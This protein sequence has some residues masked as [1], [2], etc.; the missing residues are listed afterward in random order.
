MNVLRLISPS[1]KMKKTSVFS[2][3]S[4]IF[5]VLFFNFSN[6]TLAAMFNQGPTRSSNQS[7]SGESRASSGRVLGCAVSNRK[8]SIASWRG[9]P[10]LWRVYAHKHTHTHECLHD[11]CWKSLQTQT[12]EKQ[13]NTAKKRKKMEKQLLNKCSTQSSPD[14]VCQYLWLN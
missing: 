1:W 6:K 2:F 4:R 14:D 3:I 7:L 12:T 10:S 13:K 8:W 9:F 5:I 11:V